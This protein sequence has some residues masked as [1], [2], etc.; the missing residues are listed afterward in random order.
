MLSA[1]IFVS[2]ILRW[3]HYLSE[4]PSYYVSVHTWQKKEKKTQMI[5]HPST[6]QP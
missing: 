3:D 2:V 1:S 5:T 6:N 4:H